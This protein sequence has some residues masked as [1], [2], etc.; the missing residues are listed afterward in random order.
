MV[1]IV[2]TNEKRLFLEEKA[3]EVRRE[4][5]NKELLIQ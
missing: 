4:C 1:K 3:K 5:D 2:L